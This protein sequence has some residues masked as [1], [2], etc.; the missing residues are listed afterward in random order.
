MGCVVFFFLFWSYL[1]SERDQWLF[2]TFTTWKY[3]DPLS[4]KE[5]AERTRYNFSE[6][7]ICVQFSNDIYAYLFSSLCIQIIKWNHG[8]ERLTHGNSHISCWCL[9][10]D[11]WVGF[12]TCVLEEDC[13]SFPPKNLLMLSSFFTWMHSQKVDLESY[14]ELGSVEGF[15]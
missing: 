7:T 13:F 1:W 3:E 15:A 6:C 9:G 2:K 8:L 14:V 11:A 4:C 5:I 10:V 12:K